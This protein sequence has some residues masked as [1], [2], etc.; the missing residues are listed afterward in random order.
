MKKRQLIFWM[1]MGVVLVGCGQGDSDG[2][3]LFNQIEEDVQPV[4]EVRENDFVSSDTIP[5]ELAKDTLTDQKRRE[6]IAKAIEERKRNPYPKRPKPEPIAK[7]ISKDGDVLIS[8][9]EA[10]DTS[11]YSIMKYLPI[12]IA[13]LAKI[14]NSGNKNNFSFEIQKLSPVDREWL[15]EGVIFLDGA[16]KTDAR[17][18]DLYTG[19]TCNGSICAIVYFIDIRDGYFGKILGQTGSIFVLNKHGK[20]VRRID[21]KEFGGGGTVLTDNGKYLMVQNGGRY[22]EGGGLYIQE[23]F[24]IFEVETGRRIL[25]TDKLMGTS[26]ISSHIINNCFIVRQYYS[27]K[28]GSTYHIFDPGKRVIYSLDIAGSQISLF[29]EWKSD[30]IHLRDGSA[31]LY[32]RDFEKMTFE[33]F[34]KKH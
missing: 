5:E 31:L 11:S 10:E 24:R 6:R 30:G 9:P 3:T 19:S 27:E 23:R 32:E 14:D 20:I 28:G 4:S 34:N 29:W 2:K 8:F 7:R 25:E 13:D 21:S 33:E 26:G 18:G 1:V 15:L 16:K 22:G 17:V 12:Q